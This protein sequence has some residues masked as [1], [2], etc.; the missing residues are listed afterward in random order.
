VPTSAPPTSHAASNNA[1]PRRPAASLRRRLLLA[2][3]T[4]VLLALL[5][6]GWGL[7]S[8]FAQHT[9]QQLQDQ[10]VV[11]LNQLSGAV[12]VDVQGQVRVPPWVSDPRLDTPLSGLYWQI[13]SQMPGAAARM[14]VA[15]SRSLWD[16]VLPLPADASWR[17]RPAQGYRVLQLQDD[18]HTLLAVSRHI[19]LPRDG[20]PVLRLTVAADI[21]LLAEPLQRFTTMLLI[22]LG[23]LA[24]GLLLAVA[25]QLHL[26]L[27]PLQQLR[28]DLATVRAGR[29]P[30]LTGHYPQEL[31]PLVQEFNHVLAS[32]AD[33]V[34]RARTQAGNLAHALNTPL[35][36][37][38][39]AA[40]Q[41]ASPLGQLVQ[42]QV[43][44]AR[45]HVEYHL[46]HAR[47]SAA[48]RATGLRCP[49][50]PVLQALLRTVARLH[51]HI[52][53]ALQT[54]TP[55]L[56]FKGEEQDLF[57]MLGNL[58]DNAGKW[59][60]GQVQID[61]QQLQ[62]QLC[63]TIDDDGPGIAD[64][65]QRSQIF[66]RG[67]RLDENRPGSGLGLNIVQ[68]LAHTYGGSVRADTAPLGGLRLV[69]MLPLAPAA[70]DTKK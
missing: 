3:L 16:Q 54:D 18:T 34:Q 4:W 70:R 37:L 2:T 15:R 68:E 30:A 44:Q 57:E 52:D 64:P 39:N 22:S 27:R 13:D 25:V 46:A 42:E 67:Q 58:L 49:V 32:N 29:Q 43:A 5:V 28:Q 21:A 38:T 61:V 8:L 33:M 31:L 41:D 65:A 62:G 35:S 47:A 19:H 56:A 53:F 14:A 60:H 23:T 6:A 63:I 50:Q 59:A 9:R 66:A 20:T 36:V 1:S 55:Q 17:E 69:L 48:V 12:D 45:R 51:P 7:R 24:T 10:L 40:A 26:T 11:Q